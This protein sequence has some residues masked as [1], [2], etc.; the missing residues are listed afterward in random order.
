MAAPTLFLKISR[1]SPYKMNPVDKDQI[2]VL[3]FLAALLPCNQPGASNHASFTPSVITSLS[4]GPAI[5]GRIYYTVHIPPPH[6]YSKG[7]I[8]SNTLNVT[9]ERIN[10]TQANKENNTRS[11]H[12]FFLLRFFWSVCLIK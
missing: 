1:R 12:I 3:N 6:G 11:N 2:R 7:A 4:A 5:A 9:V 10:P 8:Q